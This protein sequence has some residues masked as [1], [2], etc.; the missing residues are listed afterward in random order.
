MSAGARLAAP[1]RIHGMPPLDPSVRPA[2]WRDAL[3]Q[4]ASTLRLEAPEATRTELDA[5]LVASDAALEKLADSLM[6][7]EPEAGD[8]ARLPFVEQPITTDAQHRAI[9]VGQPDF[10][11]LANS[12][13]KGQREVTRTARHIEDARTFA[14]AAA[15]ACSVPRHAC[16]R[17]GYC[18]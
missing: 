7:G 15:P 2:A 8:I 16:N 17:D 11:A 4:I 12:L 10:A 5:L 6:N 9:D 13:G 14:H 1:P 3:H 18:R